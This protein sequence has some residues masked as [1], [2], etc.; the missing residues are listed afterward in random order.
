MPRHL[1]CLLALG[2]GIGVALA[3]CGSVGRE[4]AA[5]DPVPSTSTT[6]TTSTRSSSTATSS[7][8][9]STSVVTPTTT[10]IPIGVDC[11]SQPLLRWDTVPEARPTPEEAVRWWTDQPL[12]VTAGRVLV[13]ADD[14]VR[15][16]G[17]PTAI[18]PVYVSVRDGVPA[19]T[20]G[21]THS[22]EGWRATPFEGCR[23]D[24]P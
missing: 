24:L 7:T 1:A 2:A 9:T 20:F 6:S 8:S 3:G 19:Y 10:W 15:L 16:V 11:S 13:L 21:L 22:A 14:E 17:D 23:R 5:V 12:P 18:D 4:Q